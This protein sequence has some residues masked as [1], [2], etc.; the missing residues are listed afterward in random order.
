MDNLYFLEDIF[1]SDGME[2]A[3]EISKFDHETEGANQS[4]M[5]QMMDTNPV[6]SPEK[7]AHERFQ[8]KKDAFALIRPAGAGHLRIAEQSMAQIACAVYRSKP[9]RF[10]RII[11]I[12]MG[13]LLFRYINDEERSV[14][15]LVLDILVADSGFYLESLMFKDIA[16]MEIS[17]DFTINSIKMRQNRVQFEGLKSAAM[18]KLKYFVENY[19][20]SGS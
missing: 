13:G 7:R 6:K 20:L 17:D 19:T 10:G 18:K 16:D 15:S 11:D 14:R 1:Q 12:S 8:A 9:V 5:M 3:D 4:L 2:I